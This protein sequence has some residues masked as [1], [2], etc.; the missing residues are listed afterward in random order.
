MP[1]R[2][3]DYDGEF[4]SLGW[5]VYDWTRKYLQVP[6]GPLAGEPLELTDEQLTILVR[7]YGL[8]DKGHWLYRR[9][10]K[11]APQGW[12]K[13]P[14]LGAICLAE[15]AG[16]TVFDGWDS[17]G[18]PV[19]VA[20]GSPWVQV[21]AV[22]EDQTDNTFAA[23]YAMVS[24]SELA[25]SVVDVGATRMFL[26]GRQGRLEPV[27]A[28]AG[29]RLGQRI[30]FAVLDETHLWT[31]RNGGVKLAATI[32][33]NAGKMNGR[34]FEST[35]APL[36]GEDSVA[37]K[38]WKASVAGAAGLLYDA[39]EAPPVEDLTDTTAVRAALVQSYGDSVRW[40]DLDRLVLEIADP[41]TDPADT[42]RFYFNQ[43]TSGGECPFDMLV[44]DELADPDRQVKKGARVGV[45][46]VGFSNDRTVLF[47][48]TDDWHLFRIAVWAKPP[49]ADDDWRVPRLDVDTLLRE[50]FSKYRVR[51]MFA[52]PPMWR[53]ELEVWQSRWGARV[54]ALET[55]VASRFA[56]RCDRFAT[57]IRERTLSHDGD[58]DLRAALAASARRQVRLNDDETD[59][60]TQF[61]ITKTDS[62]KIDDAVTAI[63]ALGAI[64]PKKSARL[65]SMADYLCPQCGDLKADCG[66]KELV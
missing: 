4:P 55:R 65:V 60:R 56:P 11:R 42:R 54:L 24:N 39:V 25:G 16:P 47:G 33:R 26:A 66:C 12:G 3:P 36:I 17:Q 63:L 61:V 18:E 45:G 57:A 8:D 51:G 37:E 49:G 15:L 5:A 38:T 13:S 2:G 64:P 30:T 46:F 22:S 7:W 31:S 52:D 29:S 23:A 14:F 27:T 43:L 20:P 58:V 35:N 50:T 53:S 41:S 19:G 48:C 44:W 9:G 40:V 62:R 28:S 59:G 21:A 1:W 32:R 34:T 10:A 6:D